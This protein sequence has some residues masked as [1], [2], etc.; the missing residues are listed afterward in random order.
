[1]EIEIKE[2]INRASK[3]QKEVDEQFLPKAE[4][5]PSKKNHIVFEPIFKG[6]RSYIERICH[7]INGAYE[8]GWYDASS[9]MI[10]RL[11]E[12][13]IIEL[14]EAKEISHKIQSGGNFLYLRDLISVTLSET[15][16]NLGRNTKTALGK[17]KDIGDKSAHSRR[18]VAVRQDI[19]EVKIELRAAVQELILLAEL[20]K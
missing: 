18:Y 3:I 20:K 12:T 11:L 19:D 16:W 1:M 10:R 8:N 7:Q 13:L 5:N 4:G 14:F 9:V 6:T 2:F 17:L 15:S